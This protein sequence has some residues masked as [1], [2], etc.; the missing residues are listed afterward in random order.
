MPQRIIFPEKGQ[1]S[2][3]PF[4]LPAVGPDDIRVRTHFSLI[5]IGTETII[6][7]QRYDPD[8]HFAKIFSFPQLKTGV[9]AVGE[10]EEVGEDV[11][12]FGIGNMIFMRMAHGSHQ[13]LAAGACSPVPEGVDIQAACWCGLAKTAFRAAWAGRFELG[14]R[15]LIIGAG[16]VGQM[17]TR[18]ASSAGAGTIAV[19]DMAANRLDHA[20]VGGATDLFDK[21]ISDCLDDIIS[22][23]GGDGFPVVVDTTGNP[24]VFR[25]AL[26]AAGKFGKVILLGDTGY[27]SRQCLGSD[28]MVK[29]LTIQATHDSHDVD[30]WT[31]RRVDALFYRLI[32]AGRFD[33]SG[34]ITHEFS[35]RDCGQA[36]ALANDNREQ[37]MGILYQ[38]EG[39]DW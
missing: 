28:V 27:P 10:V 6:L 30:G 4:E 5:S 9:Q 35:P 8:T 3:E 22:L 16:P 20:R 2:L 32:Q 15:I 37:A 38:W 17:A 39:G 18:W 25:P 26:A 24:D 36:Y 14:S 7:N 12:E 34:L 19:V 21:G 33:L 31:Q 23:A 11:S 1:V 29:G 13:V